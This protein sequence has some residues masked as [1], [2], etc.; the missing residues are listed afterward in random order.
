MDTEHGKSVGQQ[1]GPKQSAHHELCRRY[2]P[3]RHGV[4]TVLHVCFAVGLTKGLRTGGY[5]RGPVYSIFRRQ[6]QRRNS[7]VHNTWGRF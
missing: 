7:D 1:V 5:G 3:S 4:K 2:Q 6:L